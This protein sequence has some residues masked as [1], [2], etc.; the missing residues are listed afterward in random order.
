VAITRG[1]SCRF[2]CWHVAGKAFP[3]IERPS[4][5]VS[6]IRQNK[7]NSATLILL[8]LHAL[9]LRDVTKTCDCPDFFEFGRLSRVAT[10][11]LWLR[12]STFR[13]LV[14][15]T[16]RRE[17]SGKVPAVMAVI[18]I[19]CLRN[20]SAHPRTRIQITSRFVSDIWELVLF[21]STI[22]VFLVRGYANCDG[23][24]VPNLGFWCYG[25][26]SWLRNHSPD[27]GV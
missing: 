3:A 23:I 8:K 26:N 25:D 19:L 11:R 10:T 14:F 9:R 17:R 15:R 6:M 1:W 12:H 7:N 4:S 24:T 18:R 22:I 13:A 16:M 2:A 5:S 27:F 21:R 20:I